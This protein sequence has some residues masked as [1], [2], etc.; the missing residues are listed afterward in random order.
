M[1]LVHSID[2]EALCNI[3][4]CL[5]E[6]V[7]IIEY[8]QQNSYLNEEK[9]QIWRVYHWTDK[10]R[11]ACYTDTD[12]NPI[13]K[14]HP[15]IDI[16]PFDMVEFKVNQGFLTVENSI[17]HNQKN[18]LTVFNLFILWGILAVSLFF[19]PDLFA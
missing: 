4:K 12:E 11:L 9:F 2:V 6:I 7:E 13:Y 3:H 5:K 19:L 10:I 8:E 15:L 17:I 18:K 1:N 16:K 14:T